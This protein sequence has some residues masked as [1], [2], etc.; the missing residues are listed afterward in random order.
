MAGTKIMQCDC[1][2]E[3]QDKMYGKNMRVHNLT[4]NKEK[5]SCSVCEGGAKYAKRNALT[6][7]PTT[8]RKSKGAR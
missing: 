6:S 1:P 3:F 5:A 8:N 7:P 4:A 2:N